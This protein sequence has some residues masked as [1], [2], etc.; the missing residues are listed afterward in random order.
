MFVMVPLAALFTQA[1]AICRFDGCVNFFA[2]PA[3]HE[4][5]GSLNLYRIHYD[6]I[7]VVG[8]AGSIPEDTVDTIS[9]IESEKINSGVLVSHILG[10]KAVPEA[11]LAMEKP[12][13]AKKVCY[14]NIDIPLVA[15]ADFEKMGEENPLFRDLDRIVKANGG[16]WCTEAENYLLTYG[17]K[18]MEA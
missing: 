1:E 14:N 8:T 15:L 10:L 6:G 13:G 9:L 2:G 7:H 5:Q 18:L 4:L 3:V 12:N 11:I 17:P 16:V